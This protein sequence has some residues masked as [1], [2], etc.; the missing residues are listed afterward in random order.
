MGGNHTRHVFLWR[1]LCHLH[2]CV[3][4]PY[5]LWLCVETEILF[6]R[7][8]RQPGN[9]S[10]RFQILFLGCADKHD[11]KSSCIDLQPQRRVVLIGVLSA[12]AVQVARRG[13]MFTL[14]TP[15][16]W[17]AQRHLESKNTVNYAMVKVTWNKTQAIQ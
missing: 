10:F 16:L 9:W 12:Q 17:T 5:D 14:C 4:I 8:K 13:L 15:C 11:W 1:V 6:V 3:Y 7:K 2:Q